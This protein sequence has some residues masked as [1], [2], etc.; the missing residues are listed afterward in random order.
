MKYDAITDQT[1]CTFLTFSCLDMIIVQLSKI[2]IIIG[3]YIIS[4]N[5]KWSLL[6]VDGYNLGF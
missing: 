6:Y 3:I 4:L 5:G 2:S 1:N